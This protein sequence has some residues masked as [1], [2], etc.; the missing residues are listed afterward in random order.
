MEYVIILIET[1]VFHVAMNWIRAHRE[2][3]GLDRTVGLV[4]SFYRVNSNEA[5]GDS[6]DATNGAGMQFGT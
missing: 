2:H 3:I 6:D 4:R 5:A 1:R